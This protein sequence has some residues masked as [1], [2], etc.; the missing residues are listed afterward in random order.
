MPAM[1]STYVFTFKKMYSV[2]DVDIPKINTRVNIV[3]HI[4]TDVT[5]FESIIGTVNW[6]SSETLLVA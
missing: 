4:F 6:L 3:R 2:M 5:D 1:Y